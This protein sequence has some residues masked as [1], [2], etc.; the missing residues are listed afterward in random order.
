[1]VH[2]ASTYMLDMAVIGNN[3]LDLADRGKFAK[4]NFPLF[5]MAVH[6]LLLGADSDS[7]VRHVSV[8]LT[9]FTPQVS[10]QDPRPFS[11]DL[12]ELCSGDETLKCYDT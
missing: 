1:M 6:S 2:G 4:Y 11:H 9:C 10:S 7:L 3:D 8:A 12:G 5:N